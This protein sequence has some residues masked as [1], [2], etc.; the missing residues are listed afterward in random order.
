MG[1]NI[2]ITQRPVNS[3][4]FYK[5]K[6]STSTES[7]KIWLNLHNDQG[8]FSQILIGFIE[9]ATNGIDRDYD[10]TRIFGDNPVALYSICEDIKLAI[11][12]R[13]LRTELEVIPLGIYTSITTAVNLQISI[14][15]L[16]GQLVNTGIEIILEDQLLG[17][18]HDLKN[19][20]YSFDLSGEGSHDDRFN[21]IIKELNVLNIDSF[22][23]DDNLILK[24]NGNQLN[25]QTE[26][27]KII[28]S[29]Q[30]FDCMGRKIID[31]NPDDNDFSVNTVNLK[32][33]TVLILNVILSSNQQLS[34]KIILLN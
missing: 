1:Q 5:T 28:S 13:M 21:I 32:K 17:I 33:G 8:A 25:V 26:N 12:G 20:S 29:F 23:K 9:G 27:K 31:I 34:K 30:A 24:H 18:Q 16:Q 3:L 11:Q 22:N 15:E 10:G 7:D 19:G 6:P 2:N 4:D 14:D